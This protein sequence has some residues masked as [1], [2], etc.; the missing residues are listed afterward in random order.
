[1]ASKW[2]CILVWLGLS[3]IVPGCRLAEREMRDRTPQ[4]CANCHT[5]IAA[6]WER[7]AHAV[8]WTNPEFIRETEERS[9]DRLL[10]V[11]CLAA[12]AGATARRTRPTSGSPAAVRHRVPHVSPTGR[13]L[14]GT[15]RKSARSASHACGP[16]RLPCSDFCGI[17]HETEAEEHATLYLASSAANQRSCAQCHMPAYRDRLT[18]GHVLSYIHPKRTVHNHAF[19]VWSSVVSA[20]AVEI[21]PPAATS[22]AGQPVEVAFT[23]TNRGAGHRIPSGDFGYRK[24]RVAVMLLD[25]QGQIIGLAEQ[26]VF[27]GDDLSLRRR[28]HRVP[29]ARCHPDERPRRPRPHP[30][31]TGQPRPL[32]PVHSGR[33]RMAD[34]PPWS[35]RRTTGLALSRTFLRTQPRSVEA[36]ARPFL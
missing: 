33:R 30:G 4:G 24:L 23:L 10:A 27:P 34:D 15:A 26:S 19:P 9:V 7:S 25:R 22:A 14:R 17:C 31:R 3:A 20:D 21:G 6:Q 8:A 35:L 1:M 2:P 5:N 28:R 36:S 12:A 11:P 13:R 29:T 32:V 18:Q 16:V